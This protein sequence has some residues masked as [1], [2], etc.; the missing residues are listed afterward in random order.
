MS[1]S[2][3]PILLLA[4]AGGF[5]TPVLADT[6]AGAAFARPHQLVD[7][8]GRRMNL[9]C[10]GNGP[11]TVVFDAYSGGAG[12]TWFAVQPEVAK[13]TRACVYDR[14]GLG[15][16]DPSPRPATSGNA[17]DDLH[18]LL[19]AAGIAPPYLMVGN[20]YGGGNVQLYAYRHRAEVKGLVLVEPQ[21]EDETPR[22]VKASGGKLQ[23]LYDQM[24]QRDAA[25]AAQA[26]Q[27]FV[28]GSEL[29]E[30]CV[31]PL[32]PQYG[33]SLGAVAMAAQ[34]SASYWRTNLA[35]AQ[36]M[37]QSGAELRAARAPL[38]DLPLMVLSRGLPQ[39]AIPGRPQ[40]PTNKAMENE[41]VAIHKELAALSTRGS[42]R[43]VPGSLHLIQDTQPQAVVKAVIEILNIAVQK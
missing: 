11:V 42:H 7:V 1:F 40:S 5:S 22:L 35:E 29:W 28:P 13:H 26:G 36:G 17:V 15:F 24:A 30:M 23:G 8:G 32:P 41:N 20:S 3:L 33:R 37:D 31:G 9:F 4:V 43:I 12:W 27:G 25:C 16:S 2:R 38:G 34:R 18:T 6:D 14:A 10:S 19:G 39:Y 21:H